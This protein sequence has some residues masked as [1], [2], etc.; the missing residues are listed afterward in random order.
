MKKFYVGAKFIL[1][2][3][4]VIEIIDKFKGEQTNKRNMQSG[5]LCTGYKSKSCTY[6]LNTGQRV[7]GYTLNKMIK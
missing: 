3:D 2:N 7:T 4:I 5:I 6:L 1:K